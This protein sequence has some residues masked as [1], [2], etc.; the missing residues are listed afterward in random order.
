MSD[1][2]QRKL[3]RSKE[4][5]VS[6]T[7]LPDDIGLKASL[8]LTGP[9]INEEFRTDSGLETPPTRLEHT[10]NYGGSFDSAL[11]SNLVLFRSVLSALTALNFVYY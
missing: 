7:T 3:L 4:Y 6:I 5:R 1:K 10:S 8:A 11:H 9:H 2:K